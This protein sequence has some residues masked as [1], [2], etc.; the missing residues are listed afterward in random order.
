M[1]VAILHG[2]SIGMHYHKCA[3]IVIAQLQSV[4]VS[5]NKK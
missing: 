2:E 1:Y 5:I 4:S 3:F